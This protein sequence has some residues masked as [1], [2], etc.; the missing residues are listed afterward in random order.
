MTYM[1]WN[2]IKDSDSVFEAFFPSQHE[3]K[4][5]PEKDVVW[6]YFCSFPKERFHVR[7]YFRSF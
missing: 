7:Q 6:M 4:H 1:L 3:A 2:T 5:R